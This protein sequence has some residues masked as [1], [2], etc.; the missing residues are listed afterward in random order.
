M[1][2]LFRRASR[3]S[4]ASI[5]RIAVGSIYLAFPIIVEPYHFQLFLETLYILLDCLA[6]M[7]FVFYR[8]IFRWQSK[9]VPSHRMQDFLP[10]HARHSA[11]DVSRDV[12]L[13][14]PTWSPSPE[15]YGNMSS[16]YC[17]A[18]RGFSF[19]VYIPFLAQYACHFFSIFLWSYAFMSKRVAYWPLFGNCA[20]NLTNL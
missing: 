18:L 5:C 1:Q 2:G 16:T 14:C 9:S 19:E 6:R 4:T 8:V 15:G 3:K 7:D 10:L 13:G 20:L 17:L 11:V 12:T